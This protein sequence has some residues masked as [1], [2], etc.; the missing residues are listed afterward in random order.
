MD[1][2]P[3]Y[4]YE[5]YETE[6]Q[7]FEPLTDWTVVTLLDVLETDPNLDYPAEDT[8]FCDIGFYD[9]LN[10]MRS[11]L[12]QLA[13]RYPTCYARVYQSPAVLKE[14]ADLNLGV[15]M[16]AEASSPPINVADVPAWA[17]VYVPLALGAGCVGAIVDE[18]PSG[19]GEQFRQAIFLRR[20]VV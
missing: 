2:L 14:L 3:D 1:L 6:S 9:I 18:I 16:I 8:V 12:K 7:T 10:T 19:V 4:V 17:K 5:R 15:G 20:T 11:A 13:S